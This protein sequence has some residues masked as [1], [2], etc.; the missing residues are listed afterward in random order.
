VCSS[1]AL[2]CVAVSWAFL[3]VAVSWALSCVA[4]SLALS[5]AAVGHC[6][7]WQL[8]G[9]CRV[10]QLSIVVCCL[11]EGCRPTGSRVCWFI[12]VESGAKVYWEIAWYTG[13]LLGAV[14]II[15][16]VCHAEGKANILWCDTKHPPH[17]NGI[18]SMVC[19]A[20]GEAHISIQ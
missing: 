17:I 13:R 14:G 16:L 2:S 18:I 6:R 12:H 8:V 7:V 5:C 19:H 20:E 11:A 1:W 15:S 3:C 10:W 9:H 4:V